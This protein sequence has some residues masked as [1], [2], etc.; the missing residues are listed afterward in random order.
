VRHDR[1]GFALLAALWALVLAA[2]LAADLHARARGGLAGASA[3][4]SAARARW[5]ARGGLAHAE[6]ALRAHLAASAAAGAAL[7]TDTLLVP[8]EELDLDGVLVRVTVVDA[9]ARVQLNLA[10]AEELRTLAA[11]AGAP[12]DPAAFASA[13]AR[14]RAERAPRWTSAPED[15]LAEPLRAPPGAFHSVAELR[16]VPGVT[17][18]QYR[19]VAPY[20]TVA[21]D[22]RIDLNTAPVP[23]LA[24]L[25]G[26]DREAALAV[27]A[28]RTRAP[29]V[30][31]YEIA[32]GLPA[33]ARLHVQDAMAGLLLRVAFAPREAEVRVRASQPGRPGFAEI[34]AVAVLAGGRLAPVTQVA[35]R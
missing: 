27:A 22:G 28:R 2:A 26:F 15:S 24:T 10:T 17:G 19:A 33:N 31:A 9:R 35:E 25:P 12:G 20:L 21:S 5:A 30:T 7:G 1:R 23:V 4:R 34:R 18:E 32:G 11:E 6:E 3:A 13:V 16:A 14:W 8:V 29:Y